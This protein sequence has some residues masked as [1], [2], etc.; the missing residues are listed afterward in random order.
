[1]NVEKQIEKHITSQP[2]PKC[3][4]LRELNRLT[5]QLSPDAD[6]GFSMARTA[7]IIKFPTL[8]LDT[9]CTQS[10]MPMEKVKSF[11]KLA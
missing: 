8:R 6:Y 2:E 4:D 10:S 7:K 5:L 1:M 9:D 11:F 3:S